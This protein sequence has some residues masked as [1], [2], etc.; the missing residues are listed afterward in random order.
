MP[1][2]ELFARIRKIKR[3]GL[4]GGILSLGV[5]FEVSKAHAS[6]PSVYLCLSVYLLP[7]TCGSGCSSQALL[8]QHQACLS[9][10]PCHE[11]YG[12]GL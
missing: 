6:R 9:H 1:G 11:D 3:C 12:P 10:A 2:S 7:P 4:A 8:L 5:G